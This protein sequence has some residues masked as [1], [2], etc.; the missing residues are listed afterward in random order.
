MKK[1]GEWFNIPIPVEWEQLT[2]YHV[3]SKEIGASKAMISKWNQASMINRNN[4]RTDVNHKLQ[5]GD[6]LQLQLFKQEDYGVVPENLP[7]DV[8]FEDPHLL[9]VNKQPGIDT[10]P[11]SPNQ[12]GTLANAVAYHFQANGLQTKVR[13]IHRLDKDTSGAL[14][15]AKHDLAHSLLDTAL[16]Q[17][18]IK[19]TYVAIVEGRM[20]KHQGV[21]NSP[22][23][24]D[25]HHA[26]RRRVSPTG[27]KAI[28][29][30]QVE[31]YKS[32]KN[33]TVL[34]L[35]LE[36]GRTHQIRVHLSSIG[37][38]IIGDTL[39]GGSKKYIDRQALHAVQIQLTHP[40]TKE[41]IVTKATY[42]SDVEKL[43]NS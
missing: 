34:S 42:P 3:L 27:Q 7:L 35:Q 18:K 16:E 26:T 23:G 32:D 41:E 19:R 6:I 40:I 37:H 22:I 20:N 28:T 9:I 31:H 33:L 12:T 13:H 2:V 24:K 30:Y 43:L 17:R 21:I 39:Y 14:I 1:N 11:N 36:T 15:F 10:H 29:H 38:P 8:L 4:E 5:K 25:R